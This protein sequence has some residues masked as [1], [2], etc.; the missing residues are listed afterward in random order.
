MKYINQREYAHI[1]YTTD[2]ATEGIAPEGTKNNIKSRGCGLCC[3][4]MAVDILTDKVLGLEE[5]VSLSEANRANL[6]RGTNLNIMGPIVAEKF[7]LSYSA[8]SDLDEAIAH[9]SAGGVIVAHRGAPEGKDIGLFAK[10]GHYILLVS[11]DG[12]DFCILDPD[13]TPTKFTIPERAGRVDTSHLP[14]LY[15]SVSDVDAETKP[16][17]VKYHMLARKR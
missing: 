10:I 9:L 16:G 8:T 17:R 11:T 5:A 13:Y 14:F 3:L 2:L 6:G 1:P 12:K 7:G 15:A 4:A